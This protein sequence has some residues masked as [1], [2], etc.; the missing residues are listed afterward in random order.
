MRPGDAPDQCRGLE[1][2]EP[3]SRTCVYALIDRGALPAAVTVPPPHAAE[4]T[5]VLVSGTSARLRRLSTAA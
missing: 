3:S 4:S 1:P 5:N 2:E